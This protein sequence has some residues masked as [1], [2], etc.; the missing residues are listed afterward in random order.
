VTAAAQPPRYFVDENSL[1]LGVVL[2]RSRADVVYPGHPLLP[3]VPRRTKDEGWLPVIGRRDLVLITRDKKIR[4]R[5]IERRRLVA[6]GVRGFVLTGAGDMSTAGMVDLVLKRW[7]AIEQFESDHPAGPWL[8]SVT[9][10]GVRQLQ[11]GA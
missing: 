2:A 8:A 3:D 11:I 7:P 6:A 1:S 4:T 10:H 9:A 5:P